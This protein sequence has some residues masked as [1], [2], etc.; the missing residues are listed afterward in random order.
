MTKHRRMCGHW[1][2]S[3]GSSTSS[4]KA[5]ATARNYGSQVVLVHGQNQGLREQ[6]AR[7]LERLG[8][9]I[10]ILHEQLNQGRTLIEKFEGNAAN[11][12][13][14]VISASADNHGGPISST[15]LRPRA[16]QSVVL[17][18]GHILK[19]TNPRGNAGERPAP[20]MAVTN[21]NCLEGSALCTP[22]R[23]AASAMQRRWFVS[24]GGVSSTLR[25]ISGRGRQEPWT[26]QSSTS[27]LSPCSTD[28]TTCRWRCGKPATARTNLSGRAGSP[29]RRLTESTGLGMDRLTPAGKAR[30][31]EIRE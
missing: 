20:S 26:S 28:P 17:E 9:E 8:L 4:K 18:A 19:R 29:Q 16:R 15:G 21:G 7:V 25:K 22:P 6:V 10:V 23:L 14:A 30:A 11:V 3:T 1:A 13:F 31:S 5:S 27:C 2:G 24:T 12:G